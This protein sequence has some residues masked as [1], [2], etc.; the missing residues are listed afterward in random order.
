MSNNRKS[1]YMKFLP[2]IFDETEFEENSFIGRYLKIFE[3]ILSGID[4]EYLDKK[5]GL[6]EVLDVI[7]ELFHPRF[8]FLFGKKNE[9]FLPLLGDKELETI[10]RY[11]GFERWD[12]EKTDFLDDFLTWLASWVDLVLQE[13]WDLQKKREIIARIIPIYRMRGTKK[14]IE[15]F[16]RIYVG[17]NIEIFETPAFQVGSSHVGVNSLVGKGIMPY[18]FTV[19]ITLPKRYQEES[20]YCKVLKN[21]KDILDL[22]KPAHTTYN[23]RVITSAL[24]IGNK[25]GSIT[26]RNALIGGKFNKIVC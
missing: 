18:D 10:E 7:P 14:G 20:E 8:S 22:E 11:F 13:D 4:D 6:G 25:A 16:L 3:K 9:D 1:S 15:E 17:G 19:I 21:I 12:N 24:K 23:L 5:K 2:A 26:G